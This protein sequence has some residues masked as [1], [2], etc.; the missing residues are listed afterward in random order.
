MPQPLGVGHLLHNR[1][2][3]SSPGMLRVWKISGE[4]VTAARLRDVTNV[5]ALKQ[6]LQKLCGVSRFRQKLLFDGECLDDKTKLDSAIDIQLVLQPFCSSPKQVNQL[7]EASSAGRLDKVEEMLQHPVDPNSSRRSYTPLRS[8]CFR[9][10]VEV[11]RLLLE[12]TADASA[13]N[14]AGQ[15]PLWIAAYFGHE[16]LVSMLLQA[17]AD[18]NA[19]AIGVGDGDTPLGMASELRRVK[20][21]RMLIRAGVDVDLANGKGQTPLWK[22]SHRSFVPITQLLLGAGADFDKASEDEESPLWIAS[23]HGNLGPMYLL[24]EARADMY[25]ANCEGRTPLA[26]ASEHGQEEAA[27]LL[28]M[29]D[30]KARDSCKYD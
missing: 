10:Q 6:H 18:G 25:R 13:A 29:T 19:R 23:R 30:V 14:E 22:A 5:K 8:A 15:T 21:V 20:I 24:L 11:A 3:D 26:A 2:F 28:R 7:V 12:A 4:E 17:G 9:G 27:R 1:L 16:E